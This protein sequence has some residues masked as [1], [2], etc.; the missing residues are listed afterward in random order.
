LRFL[1]VENAGGGTLVVVAANDTDE[2]V[3]TFTLAQYGVIEGV[4]IKKVLAT[5]TASTIIGGW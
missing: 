4:A 1:R 3:Q 5:S 2:D